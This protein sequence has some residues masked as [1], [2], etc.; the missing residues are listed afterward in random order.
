METFACKN[1]DREIWRAVPGDFYADKIHV[2][3]HGGIGIDCGGHVLVA[4]VRKWHEAGNLFFCVNPT[5]PSWRRRL[6]MWLL[7]GNGKC[8]KMQKK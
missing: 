6:A 2:T 5:M 8:P 1:T 7:K 3:E 4:P